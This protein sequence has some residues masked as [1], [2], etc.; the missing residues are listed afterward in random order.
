MKNVV[1]FPLFLISLQGFSQELKMNP[2]TN[3]LLIREVIL[4]DSIKADNL[5]SITKEWFAENYVSSKDVIQ[6][7]DKEAGTIIGNGSRIINTTVNGY[8]V[9]QLN[10]TISISI[11]DFKIK[12]EM[13]NMKYSSPAGYYYTYYAEDRLSENKINTGTK[14]DV[15]LNNELKQQPEN[16]FLDLRESLKNSIKYH[17]SNKDW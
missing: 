16:A 17:S 2:E 1:F 9:V 3:K 6:L 11:K 4:L 8:L 10:Y 12:I 5:Y 13:T 15:K 14:K 7:E